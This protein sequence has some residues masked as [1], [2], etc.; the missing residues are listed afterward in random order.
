MKRAQLAQSVFAA[1]LIFGPSV[2][3]A[4]GELRFNAGKGLPFQTYLAPRP[5]DVLILSSAAGLDDYSAGLEK[6]GHHVT[7]VA[8]VGAMQA[9]L[10]ANHFDVV[11][12]SYE[13]VDAVATSVASGTGSLTQLLPVVARSARNSAA[14]RERFE[15]FVLD[16][17]SVGQYLMTINRLLSSV[18]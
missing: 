16:G 15:Q 11:I 1:I 14:V 17:A 8:D 18:R 5:A 12:A 2:A 7:V 13:S 6:A 3:L 10:M 9:A 4:C